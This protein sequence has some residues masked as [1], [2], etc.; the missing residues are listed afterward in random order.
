[1]GCIKNSKHRRPNV[2][3]LKLEVKLP[4]KVRK[5]IVSAQLAK[6]LKG[7]LGFTK[8]PL[9]ARELKQKLVRAGHYGER[10]MTNFVIFKLAS[11]ILL[12]L[13]TIPLFLKLNLS[14]ARRPC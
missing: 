4:Q 7:I 12:P 1:M 14:G 6:K 5:E 11:P 9:K 2:C 8:D 3:F 10:A 13:L